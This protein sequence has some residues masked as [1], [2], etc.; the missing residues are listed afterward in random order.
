[1]WIIEAPNS[2]GGGPPCWYSIDHS[3]S[4]QVR[5]AFC[6]ESRK[7]AMETANYYS[8]LYH[9]RIIVVPHVVN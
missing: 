3:W 9:S 2:R 4:F 1:M 6:F 5:E 7:Q 8:N